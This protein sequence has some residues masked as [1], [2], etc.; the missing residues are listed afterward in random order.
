MG[1]VRRWLGGTFSYHRILTIMF[2]PEFKA[3]T[4][5]SFLLWC[6]MAW[7]ALVEPA[8]TE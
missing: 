2:S 6:G 7:N 8:L 4:A 5:L 3:G 1:R